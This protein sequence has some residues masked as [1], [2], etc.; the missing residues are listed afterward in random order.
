MRDIPATLAASLASGVTTLAR[1]WR[2][3]RRDG[4]RLGFTD[5]DQDLV[6]TDMTFRAAS[7]MTASAAESS[8]G[9]HVDGLEIVGALDDAGLSDADLA[10][11][12]YDGAEV[13]LLLVD[14]TDV[15]SRVVVFSGALGE[16]AREGGAFK[17]EL[18]SLTH[19][20]AQPRGRIY[21][22]ACDATLGDQRCKVDL[23][24]PAHRATGA[25]SETLGP[26]GF[27]AAALLG[28]KSVFAR[29]RLVWTSGANQGA[30]AEARRHAGDFIEL[31]EAPPM[32]IAAGDAFTVTA[33][34]DKA[35]ETCRT[36]FD[37]AVN[38]RGFPQMPGNDWLTRPAR[39]N[40][41]LDGGRLV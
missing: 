23:D 14:W 11:G 4:V 29:G 30:A 35:F 32:P 34:C 40:D 41:D 36:R 15:S 1:C 20:L 16:V 2:V 39:Q 8:L 18:R 24:L 38:F 37:N 21:Q 26:R 13:D 22:S 7:G 6:F 5:H 10:R 25:V 9:L 27:Q 19:A 17:A 33:G 28:R 12:A 31:A 3:T